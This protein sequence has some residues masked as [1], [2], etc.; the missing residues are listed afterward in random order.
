MP[1]TRNLTDVEKFYIENNSEKTDAQIASL[2][3]GVGVKT[4]SKYRSEATPQKEDD[5]QSDSITETRQERVER[6]AT[7]PKSGELMSQRDGSTIMTQQASE[8]SDA[9]KIVMGAT[10]TNRQVDNNNR[11]QIH[12]PKS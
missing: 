7:G 2:M 6:L 12:R 4:I 3:S 11:N 5:K 8:V 10:V 9:R 1:K